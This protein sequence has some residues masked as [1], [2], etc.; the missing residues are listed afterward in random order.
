MSQSSLNFKNQEGRILLAIKA[1]QNKKISSLARAAK[2][3]DVPRTTLQRRL[4]GDKYRAETRANSHQLS[5]IQ[6][7][8]LIQ[9][10]LSID[11]HRIPP[12]PS[13]VQEMA[14]IILRADNPSRFKPIG[15]N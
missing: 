10:I 2:V 4:K 1:I 13:H 5:L 15:K 7:E 3:F 14:E 8:S 9:W 11:L 12:R 6:E